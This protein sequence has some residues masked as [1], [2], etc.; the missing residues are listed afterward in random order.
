MGYLLGRVV[1]EDR[2]LN[3]SL[4]I[5]SLVIYLKAN[6][7]GSGFYVKAREVGLFKDGMDKDEFWIRQ[8]KAAH[9]RYGRTHA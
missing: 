1:D 2:K 4:M 7:A 8:V 6:D 3:P 9:E 5:S